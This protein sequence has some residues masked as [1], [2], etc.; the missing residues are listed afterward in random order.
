MYNIYELRISDYS[1]LVIGKT[2]QTQLQQNFSF[3]EILQNYNRPLKAGINLRNQMY[4][5]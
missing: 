3:D 5:E 2:R 1:K 4:G